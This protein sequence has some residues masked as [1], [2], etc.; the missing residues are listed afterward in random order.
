METQLTEEIGLH[1]DVWK[2]GI[3][4]QLDELS[5]SM[6]RRAVGLNAAITHPMLIHAIMH[7][8]SMVPWLVQHV[9]VDHRAVACA[10]YCGVHDIVCGEQARNWLVCAMEIYRSGNVAYPFDEHTVQDML[11]LGGH[12][13]DSCM[14]EKIYAAGGRVDL[15]QACLPVSPG[16]FG[17]IM[18]VALLFE[19]VEVLEWVRKSVP[20]LHTVASS[21]V[22]TNAHGCDHLITWLH[23]HMD[24]RPTIS[25]YVNAW[26]TPAYAQLCA[27]MPFPHHDEVVAV[28][29]GEVPVVSDIAIMAAIVSGN[30][31]AFEEY[32][33]GFYNDVINTACDA[34]KMHPDVFKRLRNNNLDIGKTSI[35]MNGQ[36]EALMGVQLNHFDVMNIIASQHMN[37]HM[38][39]W[40]FAYGTIA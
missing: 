14:K 26:G 22:F 35:I 3:L 15:L 7:H 25:A 38:L 11:A 1:R 19:R 13:N 29:R 2:Y 37:P 28:F 21:S 36:A 8:P 10:V 18:R 4:P 39:E 6:L 20:N 17:N 24:Y 12:A 32:Y 16:A 9:A 33:K 40:M 23:A 5:R 27:I 34:M 30:M 31:A